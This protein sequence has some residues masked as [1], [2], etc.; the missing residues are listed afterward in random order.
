MVSRS[1]N[2]GGLDRFYGLS[3]NRRRHTT[4]RPTALLNVDDNRSAPRPD[5]AYPTPTAKPLSSARTGT[6]QRCR[7]TG[8]SF[9][10]LFDVMRR[11]TLYYEM[12]GKYDSEN[13]EKK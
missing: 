6:G 7:W 1:V 10:G 8:L 5:R 2:S 12:R 9:Y 3:V 4:R 13:A 11:R